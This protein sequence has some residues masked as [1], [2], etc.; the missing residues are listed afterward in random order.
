M[1]N[2]S[3]SRRTLEA[4]LLFFVVLAA[5]CGRETTADRSAD[6][7]ESVSPKATAVQGSPIS[8]ILAFK[9]PKLGGGEVIGSEFQGS[10]LAIWFWAPW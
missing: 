9:A 10:D 3:T 5:A 1:G 8:K 6:S 7:V 4:L 2:S